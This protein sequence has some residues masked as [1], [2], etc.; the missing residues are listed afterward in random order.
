MY[1]T[2]LIIFPFLKLILSV[3]LTHLPVRVSVHMCRSKEWIS[4][5]GCDLTGKDDLVSYTPEPLTIFPWGSN[6][7]VLIALARGSPCLSRVVEGI[8]AAVG[9]PGLFQATVNAFRLGR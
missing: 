3:H 6:R 4:C 2:A 5:G 7:N 9:Q 8:F 1:C